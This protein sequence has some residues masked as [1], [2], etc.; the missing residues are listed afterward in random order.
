VIIQ[1]KHIFF[2]NEDLGWVATTA[3]FMTIS[4]VEIFETTQ[5][6]KEY[7][8]NFNYPAGT[9][10]INFQTNNGRRSQ[11]VVKE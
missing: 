6:K 8:F 4:M 3:V 2:S 10:L 11:M 1:N 5:G 9:Y 7:S